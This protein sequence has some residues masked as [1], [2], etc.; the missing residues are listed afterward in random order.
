MADEKTPDT[1]SAASQTDS[2]EET[3]D[4]SLQNDCPNNLN[5]NVC[6]VYSSRCNLFYVF[7]F[8]SLFFVFK[9]FVNSFYELQTMLLSIHSLLNELCFNVRQLMSFNKCCDKPSETKTEEKDKTEK[10][11]VIDDLNLKNMVQIIENLE[12]LFRSG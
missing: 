1:I 10:N 9:Y 3:I 5:K 12:S 11:K 8:V 7:I 2:Q 6:V 4:N